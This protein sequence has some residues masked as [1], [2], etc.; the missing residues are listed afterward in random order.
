MAYL[1]NIRIDQK[2][3]NSGIAKGKKCKKGNTAATP[4]QKGLLLGGAGAMGLGVGGMTANII[5][6]RPDTQF[7]KSM[8]AFAGGGALVALSRYVQGKR[9]GDKKMEREG[10]NTAIAGGTI[11][12]VSTALGSRRVNRQLNRAGEAFKRTEPGKVLQKA[13]AKGWDKF[14]KVARRVANR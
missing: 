9:T 4:L 5:Q 6:K 1:G 13:G 7:N 11:S 14:T 12:A 2:C 10:R 8:G 3:G